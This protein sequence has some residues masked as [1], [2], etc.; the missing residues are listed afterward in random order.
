MGEAY[1]NQ[2]GEAQKMK[3]AEAARGKWHGIMQKFGIDD[4]FLKNKHG[5]CP[6][7]G[8]SDR[9]RFDDKDGSGS[10]YCNQCGSGSGFDLLKLFTGRDFKEIA[11]EIDRIVGTVIVENRM[12]IKDPR[13]RLRRVAKELVQMVEGDDVD[14][15][16]KGRGISYRDPIVKRH[17]RMTYYDDGKPVS[18]FPAMVSLFVGQD[19]SPITYHVVYIQDGKKAPVDAP[20][21]ILPPLARM[22]G[23]A[24]RIG[25]DAE[26]IGV[27]EGVETALR[28]VEFAGI[29]VWACTS[30]K[31][32]ESFQPPESVKFVTVY[33]D[34]DSNYT[35]QRAAYILA[36][37][38][39][40]SGT[41]AVVAVPNI[42]DTDWLDILNV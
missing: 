11:S 2:G 39:I 12:P 15:Y 23:G 3:T 7:C 8:G 22:A 9:F 17:K 14:L 10:W 24:I 6:V 4:S 30:A 16:L 19:G 5:P 32:L 35:G 33:S 20:K 41:R 29:P 40:M 31:L 27:C 1:A 18:T 25:G 36:N 42:P 28:L 13:P 34:N 21:K 37:R 26:S 38:L